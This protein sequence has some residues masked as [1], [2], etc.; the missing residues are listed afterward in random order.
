MHYST[1][2]G[3]IFFLFVLILLYVRKEIRK[4]DDKNYVQFFFQVSWQ[5]VSRLVGLEEFMVVTQTHNGYHFSVTVL[6]QHTLN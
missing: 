6:V 1:Y 3:L 5:H 2:I 4:K